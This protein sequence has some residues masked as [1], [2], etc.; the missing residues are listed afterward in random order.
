MGAGLTLMVAGLLTMTLSASVLADGVSSAAAQTTAADESTGKVELEEVVVTA[1]KRSE[2]LESVPVAVSVVSSESLENLHA[3]TLESLY[4]SVP[5]VQFNHYVNTPDVAAFFIRGMGILE[6]DPYAGQTVEIVVDGVPQYFSMGAMVD[7]YDIDHIEVLRGPQGTLFGAN[8]TGGVVNVITKQPTGQLGGTLEVT[9]GEWNRFDM[10]GAFDFP[11]IDD[12]LAGKV[13]FNHTQREGWITNVVNGESMGD[14]D[15]DDFRGYLKLT[16]PGTNFD[17]T[18]QFE[19][20]RGRDG[21]PVQVNG[22]VPGEALYVPAGTVIPGSLLPMY[23]SPCTSLLLPCHAPSQY[24]GANNS[25]DDVSNLDTE[26]V[27]WTS[28]WHGTPIGDITSITASKH[29]HLFEETDQDGTPEFLLDTLRNT[30]LWQVSQEVRSNWDINDR[31]N[32]VYGLF[33]LDDRYHHLQ[34]SLIPYALPGIRQD[35]LQNEGNWSAS[36]FAQATVKVTNALKAEL[37]I[38]YTHERSAMEA[39]IERYNVPATPQQWI[40]GTFNPDGSFATGGR[41]NWNNEGG[42]AALDYQID[43]GRMVYASWTRGFKS[44]GFTGRVGIPQ[45]VGPYNPEYVD[46]YE[47]GLKADWLDRRLRTN[48]DG[49]YTKYRDM[50]LAEEYI[51]SVPGNNYVQGNSILNVASAII[52]GIEFDGS[53]VPFR[54]LTLTESFT[55]LDAY[56]VNFPYTEINAIAT[57]VVNLAG[58]T[59]QNSPKWVNSLGFNYETPLS[60]GKLTF[61]MKYNYTDKKFLTSQVDAPRSTIQATNFVD[62]N[63]DWSPDGGK[64]SLGLWGTNIFDRHYLAN[65]YDFPG[66]FAFVQYA[67]PRQWGG[68]VRYHF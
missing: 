28:N 15:H 7:T 64:W 56:Y 5:S 14:V 9:Y 33:F 59:L 42:K 21:A 57:T 58:H 19:Y 22:G 23:A 10:M 47:V 48:L 51:T 2:N 27:T 8:T 49:F 62:G 60:I 68:T 13:V 1:E 52:K 18:L 29:I 50:Q 4:G 12:L 39:D 20:V 24:Y 55:Y 17:S 11:I 41:R 16:P 67:A 66:T 6:A 54:G 46:T 63:I 65:V 31:L 43:D 25:V 37:G 26:A 30:T 35:N 44:G 38:R 40:G 34:S 3:Q 61:G 36:G 45:D 53:A 32:A